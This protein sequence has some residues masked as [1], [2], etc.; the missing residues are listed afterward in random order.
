[1]LNHL[2]II[3]DIYLVTNEQ[4]EDLALKC[5]RYIYTSTQWCP[6][7]QYRYLF[8]VYYIA[9]TQLYYILYC[10]VIYPIPSTQIGACF[11]PQYKEEQ[12]L[13]P[14]QKERELVVSI[15]ISCFERIRL[16]EGNIFITILSRYIIYFSTNPLYTSRH[17]MQMAFLFLVQ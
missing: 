14:T 12:R 6:F 1:M 16:Y 10:I 2:I 8:I 13:P 5:Q 15:Q 17:Y 7:Y 4:G 3:S 9:I 11:F